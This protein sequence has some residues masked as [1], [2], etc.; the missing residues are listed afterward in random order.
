MNL[1]VDPGF[2]HEFQK[3]VQD[4]CYQELELA[5][6]YLIDVFQFS[7]LFGST[8]GPLVSP[9]ITEEFEYPQLRQTINMVK[10]KGKLLS[11]HV[12]GVI[13]P[14]ID[15]FIQMGFDVIHPLEPC[16]GLQDIYE[17]KKRYGDRIALHGNIDVGGVLVFGTPEEVTLDVE[18]HL[19]RLAAGGGYICGS[20]HDI[21]EAVPVEN[22][23]AMRDAVQNYRLNSDRTRHHE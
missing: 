23:Y 5:F 17:V 7:V 21:T 14:Y 19:N 16:G 11:L 15:E 2:V 10:D 8:M 1:K 22:F 13:D 3:C 4:F 6:S 9:E 12:D 20:S 18:E